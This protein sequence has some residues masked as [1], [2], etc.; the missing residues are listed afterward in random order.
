MRR[1]V[2]SVFIIAVLGAFCLFATGCQKSGTNDSAPDV[3]RGYISKIQ[4]EV[5]DRILNFGP[6]VGYYFKPETPGDFTRVQFICFNEHNFYTK[7]LPENAKLFEGTAILTR[8]PK[9]GFDMPESSR[10]NPVY[11]SD[12]PAEW[13]ATRPEPKDAFVHF[14][15]CYDAQG[16]V[17]TGYWIRHVAVSE[18]TYDM[19]GRVGPDSPL[20]HKVS[21]GTDKNFAKIIEF[22]YGPD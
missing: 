7:D 22:D 2:K 9:A 21:P 1:T 5:R 8:L 13:L 11:F 18:F 12:A 3:P 20:Y 14:H 16:A 15:S 6:F 17:L 19:G 4:V 10:I